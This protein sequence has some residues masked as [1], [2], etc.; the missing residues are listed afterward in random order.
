MIRFIIER[1]LQ[2]NICGMHSK[3]FETIDLDVPELEARLRA[4]G[5]G[6]NG[7]D[8]RTLIGVEINPVPGGVL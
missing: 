1:S 5:Y 7:H 3:T 2:E 4:G 6:E 8:I